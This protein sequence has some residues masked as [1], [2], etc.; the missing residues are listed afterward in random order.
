[1]VRWYDHIGL[2]WRTGKQIVGVKTEIKEHSQVCKISPT[3]ENFR[4]ISNDNNSLKLKIK[5]SLYIK[6]DRTNL[7]KNV[8]STP[9]YLF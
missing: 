1:M 3:V 6:R 2:S 9:L 4:I 5:E 7:N 8:Y